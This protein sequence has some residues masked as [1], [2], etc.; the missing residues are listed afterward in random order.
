MASRQKVQIQ[1][2]TDKGQ[3][4]TEIDDQWEAV[5]SFTAAKEG[6]HNYATVCH[7]LWPFDP[8]PHLLLRL[9]HR[10]NW[11][12]ASGDYA[13]FRTGLLETFFNAVL[14]QNAN[15]AV[16]NEPVLSYKDMEDLLRHQLRSNH[17][18]TDPPV[19]ERSKKNKTGKAATPTQ[20]PN[21]YG[22]KSSNAGGKNDYK[23]SD[24]KLTCFR[25]NSISGLSCTNKIVDT[26]YPLCEA[27]TGAKYAHRCSAPGPNGSGICE[28]KHRRKDHK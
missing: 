7:L 24:G 12:S 10:Y 17:V 23:T 14:Q 27:A 9:M 16:N 11:L 28:K 4:A 5:G 25:Y 26:S 20:K 19:T 2:M 21:A 22:Q 3:V 18:S 1:K 8:T 15:R 6:F 13:E